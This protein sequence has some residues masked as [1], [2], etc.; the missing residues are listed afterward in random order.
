MSMENAILIG[1]AASALVSGILLRRFFKRQNARPKRPLTW[2]SWAA[3]NALVLFFL[4]SLVLAGGECYYRFFNDTTDAYM[5]TKVSRHWLH[6]HDRTNGTGVRDSIEYHWAMTPGKRRITFLGDSFT[7]GHGVRDVEARFANRIRQR[8][9]GWEIHVLAINGWETGNELALLESELRDDYEFDTV[10]LVYMLNDISDL[11]PEYFLRAVRR[12]AP[13]GPLKPILNESYF[14]NA[15]YYRLRTAGDPDLGNYFRYVKALYQ[16]PL[17]EIQADRLRRLNS[18]IARRGG[19]LLVI[20]F[21]FLQSTG[22]AYPFRRIH[23]QMGELWSLLGVPH[24]DLADTLLRHPSRQVVVNRFDAHPNE[25]A[26]A[27]AA[28][29][30]EEFIQ[31]NMANPLPEPLSEAMAAPPRNPADPFSAPSTAPR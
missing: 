6:R 2:R 1:F 9:P 26:H 20:T 18:A 5:F 11:S 17:W 8:Q 14:L 31:S 3:G 15:W 12:I 22:D 25:Y 27:L 16:G 29:A 19:R 13:R 30:I 28:D 24:L 4:A 21:P 23:A 7:A 10:V